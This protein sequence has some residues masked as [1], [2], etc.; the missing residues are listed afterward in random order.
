MIDPNIRASSIQKLEEAENSQYAGFIV[1]LCTEF[2]QEDKPAEGR[3]L[4]GLYLKNMISSNDP[5]SLKTKME[6]WAH[7]DQATKE[8]A[9]QAFLTALMSQ[10]RNVAHTAAQVIAAYGIVDLPKNNGDFSTLLPTL[11]SCVQSPNVNEIN[12]I[13]AL[14]CMGYLCEGLDNEPDENGNVAL[15]KEST[16]QVLTAIVYG[17]SENSSIDMKIASIKALLNTL[18]FAS[19]NFQATGGAERDAIM[20]SIRSALIC[21]EDVQVREIAYEC[22]VVVAECYYEHLSPYLPEL[23]TIS[24]ESIQSDDEEVGIQA[25]EFWTQICIT[26]IDKN[27]DLI[28]NVDVTEVNHQYIM[29]H[30]CNTLLPIILKKFSEIEEN[31]DENDDNIANR[32]HIFLEHLSEC[33]HDIVVDIVVPYVSQYIVSQNWQERDA[34][35]SAFGFILA[36]VS[37]KKMSAIIPGA[38]G[39]L[40]NL[41]HDPNISVASTSLWCI[42]KICQFH[43]NS[44]PPDSLPTLFQA[45]ISSLSKQDVKIQGKACQAVHELAL[46]CED[47]QDQP[48]NILSSQFQ[49]LIGHL[50]SVATTYSTNEMMSKAETCENVYNSYEAINAMI[51]SSA[52]DVKPVVINVIKEII[53]RLQA[54]F[55]MQLSTQQ[56][57]DIQSNLCAV[58]GQCISKMNPDDIIINNDFTLADTIM[59]CL[60]GIVVDITSTSLQDAYTTMGFVIERLDSNFSRYAQSTM[61]L[62]LSSL[63]RPDDVTACTSAVH[64]LGDVCRA[65]GTDVYTG[66]WCDAMMTKFL[67]LLQSPQV[68]KVI[69][70]CVISTFSDVSLAIGEHFESYTSKVTNLLGKASQSAQFS[71][72]RNDEDHDEFVYSIRESILEAYTGIIISLNEA[73]KQRDFITQEDINNICNF[74]VQCCDP[75]D[76]DKPPALV[77]SAIGLLGDMAD[78]FGKDIKQIMHHATVSAV[79]KEGLEDKDI[80]EVAKWTA[81]KIQEIR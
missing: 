55:T 41:T 70:P 21:K 10:Q 14:E 61:P 75:L 73:N 52:E 46:A 16:D 1:H 22:L 58:L 59:Q 50:L 48:T 32:G 39:P 27:E 80:K 78:A 71:S 24:I 12:K 53:N 40:I 65:I 76:N 45:L 17:M 62:L 81:E 72:E 5:D 29:N 60:L 57:Q 11:V 25:I 2:A 56:K 34:A 7:C 30:Y 66:N 77:K 51:D 47:F 23:Y 20:S 49:S 37:E 26:E 63:D 38:F 54:S 44:I 36:G 18:E 6:R 15:S 35:I 19:E 9:R 28:D 69:K 64:V 79:I 33:C 31:T 74:A 43:K 13:S 42:S 4:C 8:G 67:L 3:Q 68:S